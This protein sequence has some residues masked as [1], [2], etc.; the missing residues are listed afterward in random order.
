MSRLRKA[1][2]KFQVDR[3]AYERREIRAEY[4]RVSQ[5]YAARLEKLSKATRANMVA[6]QKLLEEVNAEIEAMMSQDDLNG[7]DQP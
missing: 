4:R 1:E 6:T 5:T 7:E 3:L 2:I